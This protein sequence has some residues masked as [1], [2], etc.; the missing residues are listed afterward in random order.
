MQREPVISVRLLGQFELTVDGR[1]VHVAAGRQ[2]CLTAAL[3]LSAGRPVSSHAL[4]EWTW[5]E[6]AS[7]RSRAALHTYVRRLRQV[8][9]A[10]RLIT[11]ADGYQLDV[12][13]DCVDVLRFTDLLKAVDR[14]AGDRDPTQELALL[15]EA[16][17]LWRGP[18]L[19]DIESERLR[20]E[21]AP[22]LLLAWMRAVERRADLDLQLGRHGEVVGELR[23]VTR[24]YPLRESL[25]ER[26]IVALHRCGRTADALGVYD[27]MAK[28]LRTEL[29]VARQRG[30]AR[31]A[32]LA[33]RPS[34]A[35][36]PWPA[37]RRGRAAGAM[38][39]ALSTSG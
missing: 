20:D 17:A 21:V 34:S 9:G 3:A 13:S 36:R 18:A 30:A 4:A 2:R 32:R 28:A 29:G 1:P 15:R 26:L 39:G 25:W 33:R 11:T 24:R 38:A 6:E 27:E 37:S 7:G 5:G 35:P 22:S 19:A 14:V 10:S 16:L 23:E 12:S 31:T 8:I